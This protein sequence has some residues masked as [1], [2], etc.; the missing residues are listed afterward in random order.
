MRIAIPKN[1]ACLLLMTA[2]YFSPKF[3][4]WA[5]ILPL[6][7]RQQ[8]HGRVVFWQSTGS[9]GHSTFLGQALHIIPD[10]SHT[11]K[12]Y[13]YTFSQAKNKI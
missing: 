9:A 12:H 5:P 8:P 13:K 11:Y 2:T 4:Q 7:S 3:E 6:H 10:T 1:V